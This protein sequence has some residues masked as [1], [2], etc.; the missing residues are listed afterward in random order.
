[1]SVFKIPFAVVVIATFVNARTT[2]LVPPEDFGLLKEIAA[3]D[4][5]DRDFGDPQEAGARV[6]RSSLDGP[7]ERLIDRQIKQLKKLKCKPHVRKELVHDHLDSSSPLIDKELIPHYL[8]VKRCDPDC[9]FCGD[10][11]EGS[12]Y[13]KCQPAKRRNKKFL[14]RYYERGSPKYHEVTVRVDTK[15]KCAPVV[16]DVEV[17]E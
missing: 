15:C 11:R 5:L 14:V 10:P 4:S 16:P 2:D 9:S 7:E 6:E 3:L 13:Q 1:M 17:A 12:E 8:P